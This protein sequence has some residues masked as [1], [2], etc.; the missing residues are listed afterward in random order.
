MRL[1]PD[2][3]ILVL[4][5]HHM[6]TDGWSIT[7]LFRELTKCYEA[8]SKGELPELPELTLQY[9]EYAQWQ[10]K[11]LSGDVLSEEVGFWKESLAGAQTI[12]DFPADRRRP[13][14]HSWR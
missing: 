7:I 2:Q 10:R 12:L 4:V 13:S 8:F 9:G 1:K 3:H 14:T 6:V 5:M 11:Y